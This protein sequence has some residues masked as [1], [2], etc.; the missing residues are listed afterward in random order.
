MITRERRPAGL[1]PGNLNRLVLAGVGLLFL[2]QLYQAI[3]VN[4]FAS[5]A[6]DG[7]GYLIDKF[8]HVSVADIIFRLVLLLI[9]LTLADFQRKYR[10][11][12]LGCDMA[13]LG[14]AVGGGGWRWF[15]HLYGRDMGQNLQLF[16]EFPW[17]WVVIGSTTLACI[18][19]LCFILAFLMGEHVDALLQDWVGY[20]PRKWETL[21][22]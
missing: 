3:M 14:T 13:W 16:S 19:T 10:L 6:W 8:G 22:K 11:I 18:S 12:M 21:E 4:F 17:R 9:L 20:L 2:Y 5:D 15:L 7:G 1:P